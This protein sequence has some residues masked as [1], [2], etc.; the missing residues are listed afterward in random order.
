MNYFGFTFSIILYFNCLLW[1]QFYNI[2]GRYVLYV[3]NRWQWFSFHFNWL[4]E[5]G[6]V[7]R[8]LITII[9]ICYFAKTWNTSTLV[10]STGNTM[11]IPL[12]INSGNQWL[13]FFEC[14]WS[15]PWR[16]ND[17][18]RVLILH[19]EVPCSIPQVICSKAIQE[20]KFAKNDRI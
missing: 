7:L 12:R 4:P 3:A 17:R 19:V 2:Y 9:Q 10:L 1:K 6:A 16:A 14:I 13:C 5:D 18:V 8:L 11:H 15:M 20:A